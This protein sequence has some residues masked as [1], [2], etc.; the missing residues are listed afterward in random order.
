MPSAAT[1]DGTTLRS[2]GAAGGIPTADVIRASPGAR[3]K[4]RA[5]A[6]AL[7]RVAGRRGRT[8]RAAAKSSLTAT[9]LA[10]GRAIGVR[11]TAAMLGVMLPL[12]AAASADVAGAHVVVVDEVVV[13][14]DHDRIV[15]PPAAP[16]A[17]APADRGAD[18]EP[19]AE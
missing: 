15:M 3:A 4:P 5:C 12:S 13:V 7:T 17:P 18:G 16:P 9:V 14:V 10:R 8:I 1:T 19:N 11:S 2:A 6:D